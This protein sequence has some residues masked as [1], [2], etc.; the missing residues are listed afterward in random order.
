MSI[1]QHRFDEHLA[2]LRRYVAQNGHTNPPILYVDEVTGLP[3]G[4]WVATA[5]YGYRN[6]RLRTK[7]IQELENLSGWHWERR[8]RGRP[9]LTDRNQQIRSLHEQGVSNTVL[10][11]K[12]GVTTQRI[13]QIIKKGR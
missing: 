1:T 5:R 3:L 8:R 13:H 7:Y 10:A 6:G 4:R 2:C 11:E 9:Q 12:Y